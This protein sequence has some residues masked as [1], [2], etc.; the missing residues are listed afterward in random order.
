MRRIKSRLY[1]SSE[2]TVET[3]RFKGKEEIENGFIRS[4]MM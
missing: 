1:S 4:D 3:C 2:L